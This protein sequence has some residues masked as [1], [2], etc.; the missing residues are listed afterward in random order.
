MLHAGIGIAPGQRQKVERLC[1][2]V[3]GPPVAEDRLAVMPSGHVRYTLKTPYRD[4]TTHIVLDPL[5]L[6]TTSYNVPPGHV[7][8]LAIDTE[9]AIYQKP[10][11]TWYEIEVPYRSYRQSVLTIPHL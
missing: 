7:V 3:S 11:D 1:R 2:Y 8:T 4:G 5:D 10:G 6:F 9:G